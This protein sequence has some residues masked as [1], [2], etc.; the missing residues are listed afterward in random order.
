MNP[1]LIRRRGMMMG[2][3]DVKDDILTFTTDTG[4]STIR[5]VKN[6]EPAPISLEYSTDGT[7]WQSYTIGDT[8]NLT[9]PNDFVKLRGD[10]QITFNRNNFYSFVMTGSLYGSGDVTSLFNLIGGNYSLIT[11]PS[12]FNGCEALKSAP[13]LPSTSIGDWGYYRTFRGCSNLTQAPFLPCNGSIDAQM[14]RELFFQCSKLNYVKIAATIISDQIWS[15][16]SWLAGVAATG[17]VECNPNLN[18]PINSPNGIPSGW[19]RV[20]L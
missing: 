19:T 16:S 12:L 2:E 9:N 6:S 17:I 20:D 4:N 3:S 15:L 1:L 14:Y 5:L 11:I 18:I 7:I 13:N 8:I 10:N